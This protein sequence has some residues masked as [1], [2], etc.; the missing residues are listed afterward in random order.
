MIAY[1]KIQILTPA[2]RDSLDSRCPGLT[3]GGAKEAVTYVASENLDDLQA[4]LTK[5]RRIFVDTVSMASEDMGVLIQSERFQF[6]PRA[7]FLYE[8]E[9]RKRP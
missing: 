5:G 4:E 8:M 3:N 1:R 2:P 7:D 6:L 9:L